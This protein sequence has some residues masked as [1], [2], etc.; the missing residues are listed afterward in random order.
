MKSFFEELYTFLS[1]RCDIFFFGSE[2]QGGG[3]LNNFQAAEGLIFFDENLCSYQFV[4]DFFF[5]FSLVWEK[6][7]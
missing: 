6:C 3:V 4:V 7:S 5:V 1:V 2:N